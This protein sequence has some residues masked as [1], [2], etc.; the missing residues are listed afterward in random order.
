M[1]DADRTILRRRVT[2]R[3]FLTIA[4]TSAVAAAVTQ[5]LFSSQAL[6]APLTRF[7]VGGLTATSKTIASYIAGI[8]A[9]RMLPITDKTSWKY[10]AAIHGYGPI[11]A[12]P[13]TAW[14]TC[15]HGNPFFWSWHRMYLYWFERIVRKQS[16]DPGWTLPFW[17]WDSGELAIPALFRE[18]KKLPTLYSSNRLPAM[19]AGGTLTASTVSTKKALKAKLFTTSGSTGANDMFAGPHN[20][21]HNE[22]GAGFSV[23]ATTALDPLFWLHHCNCDRLWEVWRGKSGHSDPTSD[24]GWGSKTWTFFD[25]NGKAVTM[26]SCDVVNTA[27]A[28]KYRYQGVATPAAELC[29]NLTVCCVTPHFTVFP[30][31]IT[32]PPLGAQPIR[33]PLQIPADAR[34]KLMS[35]AADP[36]KTVYLH[37]GDV[38][39]ATAPGAVWAAFVGPPSAPIAAV[40]SGAQPANPESPYFVGTVSL[41]VNGVQDEMGG[42]AQ[43]ALPLNEALLASHS[44]PMLEITFVTQGVLLNGVHVR[45]EVRAN[46]NIGKATI[47]IE[48]QTAGN[49]KSQ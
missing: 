7:D 13:P 22:V 16:G 20:N 48:T 37:L 47:L 42:R 31:S 5:P 27:Q 39:A 29:P 46:V 34:Q 12:S 4:G 49:A 8:K 25:E 6:A 35:I 30:L 9:M 26:S 36:S 2:R 15:Q 21:V 33:V 14:G 11:V 17:A 10:Q 43:I 41:F 32:I 19:N 44:A 18:K 40:L 38:T 23:F 45:P 3:R 1:Q 24:L 28:L